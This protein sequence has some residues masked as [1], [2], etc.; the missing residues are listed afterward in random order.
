M[1]MALLAAIPHANWLEYMHWLEPIYQERIELNKDGHAVMPT[2]PGWGFS[3][4]PAAVKKYSVTRSTSSRAT[5]NSRIHHACFGA[6][7]PR[8]GE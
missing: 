4:D 8:W 3:F 2:A 6:S 1:S 7:S 5:C